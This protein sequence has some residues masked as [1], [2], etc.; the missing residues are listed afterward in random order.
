[1]KGFT[2]DTVTKKSYVLPPK[3]QQALHDELD[4]KYSIDGRAYSVHLHLTSSGNSSVNLGGRL[5]FHLPQGVG[6]SRDR[7]RSLWV[8]LDVNS[9]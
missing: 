6:M 9:K 4:L 1:M 7:K 5:D 3:V 2:I 8:N